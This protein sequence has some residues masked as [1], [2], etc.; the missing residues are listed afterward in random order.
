MQPVAQF[1]HI[2][3]VRLYSDAL[4]KVVGFDQRKQEV[5][6][7]GGQCFLKHN[8]EHSLFVLS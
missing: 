4:F 5:M 7:A 1:H 8:F 2:L 6:H 3:F